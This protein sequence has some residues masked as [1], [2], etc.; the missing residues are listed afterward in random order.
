MKELERAER[1]K[2]GIYYVYTMEEKM[3]RRVT[4]IGNG[5]HIFAPKEWMNDEVMIVRIP[6]K[7]PKEELIRIL[8]PHLD[9]IIAVFLFGSYAR[10]E[11]ESNSDMDVFIISSEKFTIQSK[12]IE[13]IVVQKDKI[14]LAKKLNPILF[15]SMIIEA[16]PIINSDYLYELRKEKINF[17]YFK[18]FLKD[19]KRMIEINKEDIERDEL[20]NQKS[21]ESSVYSLI[22]RLRGVFIINLLLKDKKYS[23]KEFKEFLIKNSKIDYEKIY[24]IYSNVKNNKKTKEEIGSEQTES[25]L[26]LL[27]KETAKIMK[28]LK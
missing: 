25:L 18:D 27:I 7:N 24:N 15:Y 13:A 6:K 14:E 11:E 4:E 3:I 1:F 22:L 20:I 17:D 26:N 28:K 10:N 12:D 5:A 19:T 9:K 23:K 2:I 21:D 8:S 16:K